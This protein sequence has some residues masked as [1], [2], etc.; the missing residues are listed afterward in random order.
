MICTVT[1]GYI[2]GSVIILTDSKPESRKEKK[3]VE[4]YNNRIN[5]LLNQKLQ[6]DKELDDDNFLGT[7]FNN[8]QTKDRIEIIIKRVVHTVKLE[9][10]IPY[11]LI[12]KYIEDEV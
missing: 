6:G 4:N 9:T 7:N 10:K 2:N 5:V 8:L 1:Y 12:I 11:K 3:T